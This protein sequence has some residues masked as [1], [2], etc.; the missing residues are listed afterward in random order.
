M[1]RFLR[2]AVLISLLSTTHGPRE[3]RPSV[4]PKRAARTVR[5]AIYHAG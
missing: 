4:T 5:G 2:A 1:R 3:R